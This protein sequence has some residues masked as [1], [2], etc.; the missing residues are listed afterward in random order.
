[1]SLRSI[2][3]EGLNEIRNFENLEWNLKQREKELARVREDHEKYK[4]AMQARLDSE[5]QKVQ[6]LVGIV[7]KFL[8]D[9]PDCAGQGG[10]DYG[11][12]DNQGFAPCSACSGTGKQIVDRVTK[13]VGALEQ[14]DKDEPEGP[15]T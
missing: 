5:T 3:E 1:M 9:C 8:K 7:G 14:D 2:L 11:E 12:E 10:F 6:L 15:K 4:K 13:V